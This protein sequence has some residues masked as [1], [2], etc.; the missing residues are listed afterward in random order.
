[1]REGNLLEICYALALFDFKWINRL[2]LIDGVWPN[3]ENVIFFLLISRQHLR[4]SNFVA[5]SL[6]VN[7]FNSP[8]KII[9][10]LH[11]LHNCFRKFANKILRWIK[12][13]MWVNGG[14]SHWLEPSCADFRYEAIIRWPAILYAIRSES[15][16]KVVIRV[17]LSFSKIQFQ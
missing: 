15:N 2:W 11:Q 8:S 1:M 5:I 7:L 17:N 9:M 4:H 6:K 16:H 10:A 12:V 14:S 3:K 13:R